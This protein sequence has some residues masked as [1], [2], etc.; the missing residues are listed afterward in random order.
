MTIQDQFTNA[1]QAP[2]GQE[3]VP[4]QVDEVVYVKRDRASGNGYNVFS[5]KEDPK[6]QAEPFLLASYRAQDLPEPLLEEFLLPDIPDYLR[7]ASDRKVHVVVSTGSGTGLALRFFQ[8]VLQPLFEQLGLSKSEPTDNEP[9]SS[10]T[11][12][13]T[14]DAQSIKRFA[15]DLTISA[16]G[17]DGSSLQ[18]TVILLSG[19]GGTIE[20]LNGKAPGD[21]ALATDVPLPIIAAL[22]LG[23][24]NGLFHSLHRPLYVTSGAQAPSP[25]ILGL[26]TLLRGQPKPLPSFRVDFT[27][28]SRTITYVSPQDTG[29]STASTG[30]VKE[31]SDT[32]SHLYGAIVASYGFHSQL[33]W[34]SDTPEYRK[35]GSKRFQM[36]AAELLKENHEYNAT[37]EVTSADGVKQSLIER[38]KHAYILATPVSNLEKTFTI[39]PASKPLDGILRIVHFGPVPAQKVMDIMMQAYNN[40]SHIGMKWEAED[41][42]AEQ[43]GYEAI[44]QVKVTSNEEDPRWRKVCIDGTIVELP[45]G[46]SMTVSIQTR[47]HLLVLVHPSINQL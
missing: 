21:D 46:G 36:V 43:V 47:P 23:T 41:G 31:Q 22:P 20:L 1:G 5:I 11:L 24:G 25:T 10:Y 33:V 12:I 38:R 2:S 15:R 8:L 18:H 7:G 37:V 44:Q 34:E 30:D 27:A 26:R 39:S 42:K 40:G 28:G 16:K 9:H 35:H 32:V 6:N 4:F 17:D 3:Q 45:R 13:I 29:P 14:Q 19:D